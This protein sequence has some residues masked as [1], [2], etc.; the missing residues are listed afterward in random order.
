MADGDR[1]DPRFDPAFQRGYEDEAAAPAVASAPQGRPAVE[2]PRQPVERPTEPE[3][4]DRPRR[5]HA[6]A[7]PPHEDAPSQRRNPFVIAA[8]VIAGLLIVGSI[9][10][11]ARLPEWRGTVQG[12]AVVDYATLEVLYFA[13]PLLFIAGIGIIVAVLL[14]AA[15]RWRRPVSE[16]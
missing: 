2:Q 8:I 4:V 1:F 9:L 15:A 12:D 11:F 7:E 16:D 10:L 3:R 5:T 13:T 14:Y 6:V